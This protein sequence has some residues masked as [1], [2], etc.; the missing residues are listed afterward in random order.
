[1]SATGQCFGTVIFWDHSILKNE[2]IVNANK[3]FDCCCAISRHYIVVSESL[4]C[5][6]SNVSGLIFEEWN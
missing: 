1:M 5:N 6:F 3:H 2:P 4:K